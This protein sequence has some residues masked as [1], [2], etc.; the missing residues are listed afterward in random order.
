M[1]SESLINFTIARVR[2]IPERMAR[3]GSADGGGVVSAGSNVWA[4]LRR[5]V[6]RSSDRAAPPATT[7]QPLVWSCL[8]GDLLGKIVDV[9]IVQG[10]YWWSLF[11]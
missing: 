8:Y 7:T 3:F 2:A 10:I 11:I 9:N 6:R 1:F 4:L 5:L